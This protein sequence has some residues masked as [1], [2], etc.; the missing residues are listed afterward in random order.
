[1][2][3]IK[4]SEV[5]VSCLEMVESRKHPHPVGVCEAN[6]GTGQTN[7][8]GGKSGASA[9]L[10]TMK[11]QLPPFLRETFGKRSSLPMLMMEGKVQVRQGSG[12]QL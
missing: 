3:V 11:R 9:L 8:A 10:R 4:T 5:V 7:Y 6:S 12:C 1:M 2:S